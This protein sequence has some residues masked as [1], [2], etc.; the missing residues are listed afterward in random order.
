MGAGREGSATSSKGGRQGP[1]AA[2]AGKEDQRLVLDQRLG[3]GFGASTLAAHLGPQLHLCYFLLDGSDLRG[4]LC[5]LSLLS[6][7]GEGDGVRPCCSM[8]QHFLPF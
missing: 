7:R 6:M 5:V 1:L 2:G 3:A 4:F 8:C